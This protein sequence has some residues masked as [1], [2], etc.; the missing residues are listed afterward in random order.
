[1]FTCSI[2]NLSYVNTYD[3]RCIFC[4]IINKNKKQD[5]MNIIICKS[6]ILQK[7]IIKKTYEYFHKND[8]IPK[9]TDIDSNVKL[10]RVNPYIFREFINSRLNNNK[11]PDIQKYKIFF[12]NCIDLNKIKTK[13]FPL[14]YNIQKLN[15]EYIENQINLEDID[16]D[17][18]NSYNKFKDE[19]YLTHE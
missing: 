7:D 13:R 15:L 17:V 4:N 8:I 9:P 3:N 5:M 12:T 11:L 10:I 14:K 16:I 18:F 1:M 2:C 6:K 19:Y